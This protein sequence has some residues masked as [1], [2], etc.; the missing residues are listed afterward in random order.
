MSNKVAYRITPKGVI[1]M[2]LGGFTDPDNEERA[3]AVA[4]A[5]AKHMHEGKTTLDSNGQSLFWLSYEEI[6][7]LYKKR[8]WWKFWG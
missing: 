5:L 1:I 4:N 3:S 7:A 8:P 2:A 6:S